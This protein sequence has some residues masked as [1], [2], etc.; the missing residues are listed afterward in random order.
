MLFRI[1]PNE[2]DIVYSYLVKITSQWSIG[3][4][5]YK[6]KDRFLILVHNSELNYLAY[7]TIVLVIHLQISAQ[8]AI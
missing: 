5:E 6:E 4:L 3:D 2:D 8:L 1:R 7:N